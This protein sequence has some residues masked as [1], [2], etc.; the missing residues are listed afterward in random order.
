MDYTKK[1]DIIRVIGEGGQGKVYQVRK[2]SKF[3]SDNA[4][5]TALGR[6]TKGVIYENT[7]EQEYQEFR[8]CI[9]EMITG[10]DPSK[11]GALKELH[12]PEYAR[13]V[14]LAEERIKREIEAMSTIKHPNL[15]QIL[16]VDPDSKWYVSKYYS[17]GTLAEKSQIFKGNFR[18]ALNSIRPLVEAVAKLPEQGYVHRDIKPQ[19][20]FIGTNDELVLGDFGLI[21]FDDNQHTRISNTYENVGSRDWMPPWAM[22]MRIEEIKP[23]FD[24]FALGKMLWS[25]VSGKPVLRLWYFNRPQFNIE[26]MFPESRHIKFANLIF[27]KC[28]VEEQKDCLP[29]ASA[30]LEQIDIVMRIIDS[31]SDMISENIKRYCKVCGIGEYM[32]IGDSPRNFGITPAGSRKMKIFTCNHCGHVQL[33]SYEELPPAWKQ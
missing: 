10:E 1:W 29:N 11:Q 22:G 18:S 16:D 8:K 3:A 4:L 19:N 15:V 32:I 33:F 13:D 21:Y 27:A 17:N 2:K 24:V 7:R 5:R 9:L 23:T 14:D 12:R 20:V 6:M 28:I 31:N 30:L 25:M 26:E